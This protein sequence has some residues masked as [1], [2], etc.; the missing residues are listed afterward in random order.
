MSNFGALAYNPRTRRVEMAAFWD[1]HFGP[2]Q[3][4]IHFAGDDK[5]YTPDETGIAA[6]GKEL[7]RLWG[8]LGSPRK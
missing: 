5:V 4:G 6:A 1:N 3:Y 8:L 7:D 2:H